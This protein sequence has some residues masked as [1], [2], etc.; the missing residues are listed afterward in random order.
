MAKVIELEEVKN[1]KEDNWNISFKIQDKKYNER[2][3]YSLLPA[4]RINKAL[5]IDVYTIN[6][7][8]K[9]IFC[10][11]KDDFLSIKNK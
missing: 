3:D 11:K 1:I 4:Q 2:I 10:V 5:G 7:W 9:Y 8:S 6:I